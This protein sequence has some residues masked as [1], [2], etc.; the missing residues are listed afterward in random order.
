MLGCHEPIPA[1]E[2]G[3]V[4]SLCSEHQSMEWALWRL[5]WWRLMNPYP[6]SL[7]YN[8]TPP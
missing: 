1:C 2:D 8:V 3:Y 5:S 7:I 4:A 6:V